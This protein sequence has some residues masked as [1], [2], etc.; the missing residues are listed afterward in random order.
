MIKLMEILHTIEE[1]GKEGLVPLE[2]WKFQHVEH[3]N[4]IGFDNDGMYH[5][6]MRTPN[7]MVCYKKGAGFMLEDK[8]KKKQMSFPSFNHMCQYFENYEQEWE[9]QS[10]L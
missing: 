8:K 10:Y 7:L 6:S 9:N 1:R 2:E 3:L 4:D 5:M